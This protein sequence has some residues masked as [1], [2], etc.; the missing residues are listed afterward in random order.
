[1]PVMPP[2]IF[3]YAVLGLANL[4]L[5]MAILSNFLFSSAAGSSD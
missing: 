2:F 4:M 3:S 5:L 1:L